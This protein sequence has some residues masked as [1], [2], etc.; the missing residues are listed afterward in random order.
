M[1]VGTASAECA[2]RISMVPPELALRRLLK[3]NHQLRLSKNAPAPRG[4]SRSTKR[5]VLCHR[6][7]WSN[8]ES[9][10]CPR[11]WNAKSTALLLP[12]SVA[13]CLLPWKGFRSSEQQKR[14]KYIG[15]RHHL[16]RDPN[17]KMMCNG[18]AIARWS[19]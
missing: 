17:N 4:R 15:L 14:A 12:W 16:R 18:C 5:F 11:K 19:D 2:E 3:S 9:H 8:G 7:L 10:L 13:P 6:R 1:K